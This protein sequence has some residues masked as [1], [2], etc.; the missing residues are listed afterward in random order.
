MGTGSAGVLD[1][2]TAQNKQRE[3]KDKKEKRKVRR[4]GKKIKNKLKKF[5]IIYPNLRGFKSKTRSIE[6][7]IEEEKP[8]MLALAE[9]LLEDEEKVKLEG[10][11][12]YKPEKKGSRGILIAVLAD[13]EN[14]TSIV[15]EDNNNGEQLWIQVRNG[16]VNLRIGLIYAPQESRTKVSELREMYKLIEEQVNI[17]KV[18]NEKIMVIGD[19][20]CK[21]GKEV[22]GNKEKVTTGGRM[23]LKLIKDRNLTV[24][25]AHPKCQG[26]WTRTEKGKKSVIDYAIIEKEQTESVEEI[27]IDEK[28]EITPYS[29]GPS[30][31]VTY[32]DHNTIKI[33]MN[34]ITTSLRQNKERLIINDQTK[35]KYKEE[36]N[37]GKLCQIWE[38]EGSLQEKYNKWTAE[39]QKITTKHFVTKKK[40]KKPINRKIR[41]LQRKRRL[42]KA[43][44]HER[45]TEMITAR[46]KVLLQLIEE[47]KEKQEKR[48]IV[49]IAENIKKESGFD[50][51][52]FW[53]FQQRSEGRKKE[54]ATAMIDDQ[55]NVE[56]DPTKI[57]EIYRTFY[58]T[59]L[60]DR[61]PDDEEEREMQQLKEKCIEVMVEKGKNI[62]IKEITSEEYEMMKKKLKKKKAPDE[63]GWRYEWILHAGKEMEESIKLMLNEVVK[64]KM[65]PDQWRNMRIKSITKKAI[66]RM[67]MNYKRG[68]FLTNVL[69]KCMERILLNR[70]KEQLDR[71]MQPNQNGGVNQRS[72][73]DVLFMINNTIAEFKQEKK[74]L[75]ILFG[76]LEKCFDKLYLKD[77][78][79]ELVEAGMPIEEAMFVY[80]MNRNIKAIVD[81][82]HGLTES[83]DIHEAVRQGT[84]FGTT[85]CGVS[86]NRINKMGLPEPLLLHETVEIGY[87]I[88]VDDM[89]GM[90]T[91]KRIEDA[92]EKMAGLERTKKYQVN[93]DKDK[94]EFMVIKNNKEEMEDIK[95]R[96]RKG[97]I[98]STDKYKCLGD[99]YDV[100]GNNEIKIKKKMEKVKFIAHE[101]K[102]KGA[103]SK[104][105]HADMAVQLLL[106]ET[107]AKPTLLSNTET[108]CNITTVE[109]NLI[110]SHHHQLLC[111]LFNQPRS[112]PYYGILGET[113]IWPYN[114][115]IIYKKLM[116]L[117][118]ITHSTN[119]RIAKKI[120]C[121]QQEMLEEGSKKST[122]FSEIY[123]QVNKMNIDIRIQIV[124]KKTKSEWKKE[125][126]EKIHLQIE[127]EF[128]EETKKKTKLRHLK[129]KSFVMEDYVANC[130]AETVGKIM[131]I[132]LNMVDTK[133]NYKGM[134]DDTTCVNCGEEE[135]TEHLLECEYY[136]QF[137][138]ERIG[139]SMGEKELCST[140]WLRKAARTMDIIQEVR[141]QHIS[142]TS[143]ALKGSNY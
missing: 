23:L 27:I 10:Y 66:K 61:E 19:L 117:H 105:G 143:P 87:P 125:V 95:I 109:E 131:S 139:K 71:S 48:R 86:T 69:S 62:G 76:D 103:A 133:C 135:T 98:G 41:K 118:H 15:M 99:N 134:Y 101:I 140:E 26:L 106:L 2:L 30:N 104:V 114:K 141:R 24:L 40:K 63:E 78:I 59:L 42:L 107:T 6:N 97:E 138:M 110:T 43:Q 67:E 17:G 3:K 121:R 77:C 137:I 14:I 83:F 51:N 7:I 130:N 35:A 28:K 115:V 45:N 16:Q 64:E 57:K 96:V 37:G 120:V 108:W 50:A 100:T 47:E 38:D 72:T 68:L 33:T 46:R 31:E 127:E 123:H 65:Q 21:I 80:E 54:P 84:I 60:K 102:R 22:N 116:F 29:K 34:W 113:G 11:K 82:P 52:A 12:I 9:T 81:T 39:V 55:G 25:N 129:N 92:G 132:R 13:L 56:E 1:T 53:Q 18:K 124:E 49:Q 32:T 70:N 112:T 128:Q 79:I 142:V 5:K 20:N 73:A 89:S 91:S 111:I 4:G 58:Q 119:D 126:K 122:W 136:E 74:D 90:G 75:Y 36:T 8:T 94:T 85:L 88:F 44:E 93:N